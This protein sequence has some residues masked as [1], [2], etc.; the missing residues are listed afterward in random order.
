MICCIS[1]EDSVVGQIQDGRLSAQCCQ[2]ISGGGDVARHLGETNQPALG[3]PQR[4]D[5]DAGEKSGPVL[6]QSPALLLVAPLGFCSLQFLVRVSSLDVFR[7]VEAGKVAAN[8]LLGGVTL[9]ALRTPV[10]TDDRP[11]WIEHEDGV[12]LHTVNQDV[13]TFLAAAQ[14]LRVPGRVRR[15]G[16]TA[17]ISHEQGSW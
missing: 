12:V 4:R 13:E 6:A 7:S 3:I 1:N 17:S 14:R 16:G 9:Q 8:N 11:G 15:L 5:Y 2:E 10:P